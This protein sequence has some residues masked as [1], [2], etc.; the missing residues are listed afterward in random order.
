M[1]W[2]QSVHF[3][4]DV[5]CMKEMLMTRSRSTFPNSAVFRTNK[6]ASWLVSCIASSFTLKPARF[7]YDTFHFSP[8]VLNQR[9]RLIFL[10]NLTSKWCWW[11]AHWFLWILSL[12]IQLSGKHVTWIHIAT[13]LCER[14]RPSSLAWSHLHLPYLWLNLHL[15]TELLRHQC[16]GHPVLLGHISISH[17]CDWIISPQSYCDIS[18]QAIQSCLVTPQSPIPVTESSHHRAIATS[19]FRVATMHTKKEFCWCTVQALEY[20]INATV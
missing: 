20:A 15:T 12:E 8:S 4:E 5:L 2:I 16:S 9:S 17:T 11:R 14:C 1:T 10:G 3:F 13:A 6:L 7:A 19:V 18:V